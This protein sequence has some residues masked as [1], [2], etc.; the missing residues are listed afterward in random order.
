MAALLTSFSPAFSCPASSSKRPVIT[1]SSFILP[2]GREHN[3]PALKTAA[4]RPRLALAWAQ[5]GDARPRARQP[6]LAG[7]H[8]HDEMERI[9]QLYL[10]IISSDS[11][12]L[13]AEATAMSARV[14][15]SANKA[16]IMASC[17][18]DSARLNLSAPSEISAETIHGTVRTYAAVFSAAAD[19]SYKKTVNRNTVASFLGA[20]RGLAAVSHIL[21]QG[22]LESLCHGHP[23]V[24]LSEYAFNSDVENMY[25]EFV[26]GMRDVE[27]EIRSASA[28]K[29]CRLVVL[30]ILASTELTGSFVGLMLDRRRR[31]LEKARSESAV[32]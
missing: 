19:D 32:V 27:D 10:D 13:Y 12:F 11:D 3:F 1:T 7:D 4:A 2:V 21:L 6:P 14:C 26:Q 24:A 22:A 31:A 23:R 30:V 5:N 9:T 15:L 28:V 16:L 8:F 18:V 20:L 17:V 25:R 29:T